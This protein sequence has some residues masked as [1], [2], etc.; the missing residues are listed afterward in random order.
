[1]TIVACPDGAGNLTSL[2]RAL[3]LWPWIPA[4][5]HE[6][7][8]EDKVRYCVWNTEV[9]NAIDVHGSDRALTDSAMVLLDDGHVEQTPAA[10]MLRTLLQR[11]WSTAAGCL[12]MRVALSEVMAGFVY[13]YACRVSPTLVEPERYLRQ[14]AITIGLGPHLA[15]D[16][17]AAGPNVAPAQV[18]VLDSVYWQLSLAARYGSDAAHV[19]RERHEGSPNIVDVWRRMEPSVGERALRRRAKER[20]RAHV[21]R[22]RELMRTHAVP[23]LAAVSASAESIVMQLLEGRPVSEIDV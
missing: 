7:V 4:A 17:A 20:S 14:S 15:V 3:T 8:V 12:R 19:E 21:R 11:R 5:D 6:S 23:G 13:E 18:G 10:A 2:A 16:L 22:A 9:D 1:M